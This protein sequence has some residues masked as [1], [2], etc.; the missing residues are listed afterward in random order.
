MAVN[1][2]VFSCR[3]DTVL[4]FKYLSH[5]NDGIVFRA[6]MEIFECA[7]KRESISTPEHNTTAQNGRRGKATKIM[8]NIVFGVTCIP[9]TKSA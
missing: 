7:S 8:T 6:C 9:K 5:Q 3:I 4:V 1:D 2:G